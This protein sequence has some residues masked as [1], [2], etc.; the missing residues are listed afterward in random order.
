MVCFLVGRRILSRKD[1]LFS[2]ILRN[3]GLLGER[4]I[5]CQVINIITACSTITYHVLKF[6]CVK[7]SAERD[8]PFLSIPLCSYSSR[9]L[10]VI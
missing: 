10:K 9:I 1:L 3:G 8:T 6:Y 7:L 5:V 2:Y 4:Y